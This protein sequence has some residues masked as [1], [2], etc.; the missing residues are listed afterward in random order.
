MNRLKDIDFTDADL[1]AVINELDPMRNE[2][3]R[4]TDEL[5]A[6]KL[7]ADVFRTVLR[8]NIST[9]AWCA[10]N[11]IIWKQD[12]GS[13]VAEKLCQRFTRS[14]EMYVIARK[15]F[16]PTETE[17]KYQQFAMKLGDRQKRIKML[18]D[19]KPWLTINETDFD[20]DSR[21]LNC[22]NCVIDL[23]TG[24]TLEHDPE[25]LLSK[26]CNVHYDSGA[27]ANQ[28][29]KFISEIMQGDPEKIE[30][31]QRILGYG[32]TGTNYEE[33]CFMFYGKTTRNG[34]STLIETVSYLLGDYAKSLPPEALAQ[35]QRDARRPNEEIARLRGIR[36]VPL[37]EP[38]K[39]MIFDVALLKNLTG[40]DT[41]TAHF[42][43]G[44][45]F[46]YV[47]AFKIFINTNYLPVVNDDSLFTSDRVHVLTFDRHFEPKEQDRNL[48]RNL[49]K[50]EVLSGI[51]NWLLEGLERYWQLGV[52]PVPAVLQATEE[53]RKDSDKM[54]KFIEECLRYDPGR[55][56]LA[57]R[58]Y[59]EY[60]KWCT[61]CGYG[62]EN[63][64][65]FLN[66]LRLR[67]MLSKSGT[68]DGA[69]QLNVVKNYSLIND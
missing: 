46:E 53:Y 19:A 66:E 61:D 20:A 5:T 63:K 2:A 18:D 11:G 50:P 23:Q 7:F 57:K 27:Y 4:I 29:D 49:R 17:S 55:N 15:S 47:P 26:V 9:K 22:Q 28:W 40:G 58:L 25:L 38:S 41:Q 51:L 39:R 54:G 10:Y 36:F 12:D 6:G 21:L 68:I 37:S 24:N 45:M 69:T 62:T 30:Y 56:T 32:I 1:Y 34:K 67:N 48:K 43:Y 16:E 14:L 3:Y 42:K 33:K 60:S 65:N 35:K 31:L 59:E 13:A 64:G 8:F 52:E 44:H